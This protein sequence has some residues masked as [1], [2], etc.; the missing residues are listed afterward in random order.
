MLAVMARIGEALGKAEKP[1]S[2]KKTAQRAPEKP[3][4]PKETKEEMEAKVAKVATLEDKIAKASKAARG[5]QNRCRSAKGL[6][7][8][9]CELLDANLTIFQL[10]KRVL[11]LQKAAPT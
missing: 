6:P 10:S 11:P 9:F 8:S 5:L 3:K 4:T 2:T 7:T 1:K